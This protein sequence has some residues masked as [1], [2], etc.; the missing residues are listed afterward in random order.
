MPLDAL[1]QWFSTL[2]TLLSGGPGQAAAI[3]DDPRFLLVSFTLALLSIAVALV[4]QRRLVPGLI[5]LS[6]AGGLGW[7]YATGEQRPFDHHL[8]RVLTAPRSAAATTAPARS[9]A[10]CEARCAGDARCLAF[11][12]DTV[13]GTCTALSEIA[14]MHRLPGTVS[15][16]RKGERLQRPARGGASR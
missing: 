12:F 10:A 16:I 11:T 5:S 7:H 13:A 3:L 9:L 1:V 15:G 6:L 8:D 14:R 2:A 4:R